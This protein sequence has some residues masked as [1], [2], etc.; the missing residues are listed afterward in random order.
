MSSAEAATPAT[1]AAGGLALSQWQT[2]TCEVG[3]LG[4]EFTRIAAGRSSVAPAKG[5]RRFGDPAWTSNPVFRMIGQGYL[6]SARALD[7]IL[8]DL[9]AGEQHPVLGPAPGLYVRDMVPL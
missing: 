2:V 4:L 3:R 6:A 8:D 7:R 9:G 5:D 1:K